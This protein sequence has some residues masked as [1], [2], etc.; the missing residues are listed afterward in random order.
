MA[1]VDRFLNFNITIGQSGFGFNFGCFSMPKFFSGMP[2]TGC[3][4]NLGCLTNFNYFS[5][6]SWFQQYSNPM[7]LNSPSVF[8]IGSNFSLPTVGYTNMYNSYGLD[9]SW[10]NNFYGPNFDTFNFTA[11]TNKGS[12][13][14]KEKVE[15]KNYSGVLAEYNPALGKRIAKI[16]LNNA[17]Y[18]FNKTTKQITNQ[19]KDPDDFTG[20]CA[21][22]VKMAIRDAGAGEYVPGHGYQMTDILKNNKNFKQISVNSLKLSELPAGT[23]LVYNRGAQGYSSQY[24]HTEVVTEDGR[25]VSDGITDNL[26]KKPSAIFIPVNA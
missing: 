11:Q 7:M 16:A 9:N 14:H 6:N 22:Y 26:Y 10:Q 1:F 19:S 15:Q 25:A 17:G 23:I 18:R 5:P 13:V 3:F 12:L 2:F 4:N 24:G 8:D 21:T 20:N